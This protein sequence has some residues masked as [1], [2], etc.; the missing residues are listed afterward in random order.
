MESE[1]ENPLV[2]LSMPAPQATGTHLVG[3]QFPVTV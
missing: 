3:N 1:N 2:I